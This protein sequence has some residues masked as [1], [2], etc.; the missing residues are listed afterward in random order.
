[1]AFDPNQPRDS[2][3]R[4]TH[5]AGLM[6]A[7]GG[8]TALADGSIATSGY[9]VGVGSADGKDWERLPHGSTTAQ[10]VKAFAA[11]HAAELAKPGRGIG[12]WSNNN[13]DW[14][15][16][17]DALDIVEVHDTLEEALKAARLAGQDAIYDLGK[18]EEIPVPKRK[19]KSVS[20]SIYTP[21]TA[22]HYDLSVM[23]GGR[24]AF[25][26][27]VLPKKEIHYT[28]KNG[29]RQVL[30]FNDRYLT[31]LANN[32]I[33]DKVGFLLADK[34][35]AHTMDPER[36]RGEV[37][38]WQIRDDQPNPDHNGLY[39]RIVFPNA[40]AARAVMQNPDLGVSA[41]IRED[42]ARSDGSTVPRG[43]VHVLG[44]LDPQVSGMSGWTTAD[45]S[46][47]TD[48]LLDLTAETYENGSTMADETK[49]E[50]TKPVSE[51]TDAEIDEM[52]DE[53]LD[54]FLEALGVDFDGI[55]DAVAEETVAPE[56]EREP[57]MALSNEMKA[58]ID[59]ARSE[60][61]AARVE[62]AEARWKQTREAY[63]NAG[64]PVKDVDLCEPIFNRPNDFVVDLSNEDGSEI[65]VG[66]I[67]SKL[68][69]S[70]KGTIDLSA[71]T[72]HAGTF[73]S[74]DG[75]DPDKA[76][77]DAWNAQS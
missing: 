34:D 69:D 65:N 75:E 26:K 9:S 22:G 60:A 58:E 23:P 31:D 27:Q 74:G 12:G 70:L 63:L 16:V 43:I 4:W 17:R 2:I 59:L 68:L 21:S 48:N 50:L 66:E 33:V 35:N 39:A 38:E 10:N 30:D 67:V 15:D 57:E 72:G 61:R 77:L 1:M 40:D 54:V 55:L 52:D 7:T 28:A 53:M 8:F 18:G 41:R 20:L 13:P 6:K 51:Y 45:L 24:L 11:K 14:G 47:E 44:T 71:E 36:W 64:V 73:N 5:L 32:K 76:L 29:T 46:T 3:G 19:G 25:W 56:P 49:V 62:L 42:V 37:A